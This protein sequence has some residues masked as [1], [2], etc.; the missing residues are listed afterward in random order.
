MLTG[1]Q[2]EI[3]AEARWAEGRGFDQLACGEHLFFHTATPNAFVA[4]A[5]AAGATERIRLLTSLT[6]A[7]LYP[8]VLLAK[9]ATTLDQVSEGRLDLGLGVGGEYPD[10]F[11]AAGV[12]VHERGRR[13][14]ETIEVLTALWT[15]AKVDH[16]GPFTRVPDLALDPQPVQRPRPPLW[17]GGRRGRAVRRA[18]RHADVWL[19]YLYTPEQL[20]HS[21]GEVR[22]EAEQCGRD[23]DTVRGAIFC[24][25]A[26]G[27]DDERARQVAVA[28][29]SEVYQQDFTDL[30]DRYLLAGSPPRILERLREYRD[31]GAETV[32]FCPGG[33]GP[34]RARML[35]LFADEVLPGA[36][37]M[38][39][40]AQIVP[41]AT[42]S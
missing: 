25:G 13:T 4:L 11:V 14:D 24:W 12:D 40:A 6:I 41:S 37:A 28:A 17:M 32:V 31:A 3:V 20:A 27:V 29:V 33:T 21:L 39:H 9:L 26:V 2:R 30:A 5:A 42:G 7:P 38:D 22:A 10:E 16:T 15:G 35:E 23:P 34:A 19:P 18:G 8:A 1:E 36:H